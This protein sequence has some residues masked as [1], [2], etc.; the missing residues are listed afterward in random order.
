[1][2]KGKG[3]GTGHPGSSGFAQSGGISHSFGGGGGGNAY[4][5]QATTGGAKGKGQQN[6][7]AS[8]TIRNEGGDATKVNGSGKNACAG[9]LGIGTRGKHVNSIT[10]HSLAPKGFGGGY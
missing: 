5:R 3:K 6:N 1:M 8:Y 7:G 10:P 4:G 9:S 2:A